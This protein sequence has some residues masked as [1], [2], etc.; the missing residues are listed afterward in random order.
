VHTW[1]ARYEAGDLEA[2]GDR[3]HRP[4]TCSHQL[5]SELEATVLELGTSVQAFAS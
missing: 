3:S 2:L 1:L 4:A 5:S